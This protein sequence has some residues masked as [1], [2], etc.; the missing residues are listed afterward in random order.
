MVLVVACSASADH[1]YS[2]IFYIF[3]PCDTS[4]S[5]ARLEHLSCSAVCQAMAVNFQTDSNFTAA[6]HFAV[7]SCKNALCVTC[8]QIN[9][10][11]PVDVA[12]RRRARNVTRRSCKP[13]CNINIW[14]FLVFGVSNNNSPADT[15][16]KMTCDCWLVILL[17]ETNESDNCISCCQ[18]RPRIR[19]FV[20]LLLFTPTKH[21]SNFIFCCSASSVIMRAPSSG[22]HDSASES[23]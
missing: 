21:F 22:R 4:C 11:P 23:V 18:I 17:C 10:Q 20:A 14:G 6:A 5:S 15:E 16:D 1:S 19:P 12:E 2:E 7:R 3:Q 9:S 8:V 13:N